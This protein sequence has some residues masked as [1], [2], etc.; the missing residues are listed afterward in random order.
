MIKEDSGCSFPSDDSLF[1]IYH[2][3]EWGYPVSDDI[4]IFEKICLEGFQSGLSWRT[5]LHRRDSFR[6]AFD[7]FD[8]TEIATYNESDVSRLV[9]DSAIIRN[10]Q[11]IRS[12]VN[13]AKRAIELK[14]EFGSLARFVWQHEPST[15][16]RPKKVTRSWVSANTTSDE[17][18]ELSKSLKL[19]GWT[20]IGP[21]N[22]YALMQAL[23][24][25]NDHTSDCPCRIHVENSR[26]SFQ[27]P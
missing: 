2:D 23:G 6:S 5:I 13:N 8:F 20:F 19:R 3:T 14:A 21:T 9:L 12:V 1:K 18:I 25:V 4:K 10:K 24:L 27:R 7:H 11:K 26:R 16:R 22:M 15:N 17:S